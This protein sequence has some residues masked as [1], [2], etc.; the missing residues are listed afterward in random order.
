MNMNMVVP[1]RGIIF[2]FTTSKGEILA[3]AEVAIINPAIG[4]RS[5]PV[6]AASC[7]VTIIRPVFKTSAEDSDS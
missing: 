7:I 2:L 4:E 5:R 3:I 6:L 1:I